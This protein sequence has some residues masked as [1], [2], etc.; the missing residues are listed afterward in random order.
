MA[1]LLTQSWGTLL[2]Q[3]L[4]RP[5]FCPR[6]DVFATCT[7]FVRFH[8]LNRGWRAASRC[9]HDFWRRVVRPFFVFELSSIDCFPDLKLSF[10]APYK[11]HPAIRVGEGL[12]YYDERRRLK[13]IGMSGEF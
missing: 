7:V 4:R 2:A 12:E 13:A 3:G 5:T 1:R 10:P 6:N 9:G 11:C 8:H